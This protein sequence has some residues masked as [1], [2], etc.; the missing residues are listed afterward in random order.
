MVFTLSQQLDAVT[1]QC[2]GD[3]AERSL[4]H[5]AMASLAGNRHHQSRC[6]GSSAAFD[7]ADPDLQRAFAGARREAVREQ[8]SPRR[9]EQMR[10]LAQHRFG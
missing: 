2:A 9:C 3:L 7:S 6:G 8:A 10:A 5:V 4:A 1:C